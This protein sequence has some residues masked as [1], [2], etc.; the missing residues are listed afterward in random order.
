M[1]KRQTE[2]TRDDASLKSESEGHIN[3]RK[4]IYEFICDSTFF[5]TE[6]NCEHR[7]VR[8]FGAKIRFQEN[9][10]EQA[11]HKEEAEVSKERRTD[12]HNIFPHKMNDIAKFN[13]E[14]EHS[15]I[16]IFIQECRE[17]SRE[18]YI[19]VK[20]KLFD[21]VAGRK[22]MYLLFEYSAGRIRRREEHAQ[23]QPKPPPQKPKTPN[24]SVTCL[25]YT[26]DA[27]DD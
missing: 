26:S 3:N 13:E 6:T 14:M 20:L 18:D 15:S 5:A 11:I 21:E 9:A 12:V 19:S 4:E 17:K 27:A 2:Y 22:E 1:Y 8:S 23:P 24:P 10:T 7:K 16:K 25:L